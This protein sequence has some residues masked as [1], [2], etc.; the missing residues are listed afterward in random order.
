M[1]ID[2]LLLNY[3]CNGQTLVNLHNAH[4]VDVIYHTLIG[5]QQALHVCWDQHRDFI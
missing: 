4:H 1:H 2:K 3:C 5:I